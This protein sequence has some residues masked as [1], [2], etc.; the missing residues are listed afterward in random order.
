M[1]T[2]FYYFLIIF[3]VFVVSCNTNKRTSNI[4]YMKMN[5]KSK[6]DLPFKVSK[7]EI[8]DLL[9]NYLPD[10]LFE[11][12][13]NEDFPVDMKIEK[14][15]IIDLNLMDSVLSVSL[16]L[17]INVSKTRWGVT[18]KTDGSML[19]DISS[20][21]NVDDKWHLIS[22]TTI[23]SIEWI[24]KPEIKAFF[25]K[26]PVPSIVLDYLDSKK[27]DLAQQLDSI[28]YEND[29]LQKSIYDL[30]SMVQH[31]FPVDSAESVGVKVK[32]DSISL[33]PFET[34]GDSIFGGISVVFDA[35]IVPMSNDTDTVYSLGNV[36]F[37]WIKDREKKQNIVFALSF[38]QN[39][40]Q[41]V[42]NA[43]MDSI[44]ERDRY[45]D[46]DK[47]KIRLDNIDVIYRNGLTGG[48]A[49][50]SGDK[51]GEIFILCRPYWDKNDSKL[52]LLDRDVKIKF[53]DLQSKTL[54]MLFGK[55]A[56]KKTAD[57]L[58]QN[59]NELIYESIYEIND[60]LS[61]INEKNTIKID[62][63]DLPV[64]LEQDLLLIDIYLYVKGRYVWKEL[65]I[66]L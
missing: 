59:I 28:L 63:F 50:I 5:E 20:M 31:P 35:Q 10:T 11:Q 33:F 61:A 46:M 43:Y 32:L 44:P 25:L 29:F 38:T 52:L 8:V 1:K 24:K 39:Q 13:D 53:D 9:D 30:D 47:L 49:Y 58:E 4:P 62:K 3:V 12:E 23:E 19:L 40:M 42:V 17:D 22:K 36:G 2:N 57:I 16:S 66:D 41:D 21:L 15:E 34:Y 37:S 45:F 27:T 55:K 65:N 48:K 26:M 51:N 54:L 60:S 18:V 14:G 7:Q 6:I 64:Q 56:K